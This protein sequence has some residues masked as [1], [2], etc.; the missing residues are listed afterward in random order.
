M[1][2]CLGCSA[3]LPL[4]Q[5][6]KPLFIHGFGVTIICPNCKAEFRYNGL[7]SFVISLLMMAMIV[8]A[9]NL[10]KINLFANIVLSLIILNTIYIFLFIAFCPLRQQRKP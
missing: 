4:G 5:L 10:F 8:A 7:V 6:I 3:K 1:K 2:Q 9:I